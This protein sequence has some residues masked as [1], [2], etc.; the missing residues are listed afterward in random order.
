M[1][2]ADADTA[3]DPRQRRATSMVRAGSTTPW[4]QKVALVV[5]VQDSELS[6]RMG[7]SV[8]D[9]EEEEEGIGWRG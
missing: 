7:R 6:G 3:K 2:V 8:V 4:A 5:A 9:L 1:V